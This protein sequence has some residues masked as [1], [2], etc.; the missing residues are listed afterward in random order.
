MF[1]NE[2]TFDERRYKLKIRLRVD[3]E[4]VLQRADNHIL[5]Q[6][7]TTRLSTDFAAVPLDVS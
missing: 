7:L 3:E 1:S 5:I 6:R 2:N 4:L